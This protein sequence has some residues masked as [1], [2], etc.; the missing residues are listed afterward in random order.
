MQGAMKHTFSKILM[1]VIFLIVISCQNDIIIKELIDINSPIEMTVIIAD[2]VTGLT[3]YKN[4]Q[5]DTKSEKFK[6]L[7]DFAERNSQDWESSVASYVSDI[8]ISQGDF[9]LLY[10][11]GKDGVVIGFTDSN[12]DSKQY[13]KGI[14]P[15]EL[16]FLIK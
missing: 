4:L 12:G 2:S 3:E 16:D 8:A 15:G 6:Q 1:G 10:W 7:I 9:R 13:Y 11:I 14:N 5:I